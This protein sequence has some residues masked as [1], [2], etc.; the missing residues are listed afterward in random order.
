MVTIKSVLIPSNY[1]VSSLLYHITRVS[2]DS[3]ANTL[4]VD[5]ISTSNGTLD[6]NDDLKQLAL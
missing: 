6:F 2:I 4:E 1:F 5:S 3:L